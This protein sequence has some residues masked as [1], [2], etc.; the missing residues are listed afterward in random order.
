MSNHNLILVAQV[1]Q[2]LT[3][4]ASISLNADSVKAVT[5]S[6]VE[7]NLQADDAIDVK[8]LPREVINLKTFLDHLRGIK[9]TIE[10]DNLAGNSYTR[11]RQGHIEGNRPSYM[12][13]GSLKQYKLGVCCLHGIGA[14]RAANSQF[15]GSLTAHVDAVVLHA[16]SNAPT[17]LG[18]GGT[19]LWN[20][21]FSAAASRTK[22]F[23]ALILGFMVQTPD[24]D[25]NAPPPPQ[26][27]PASSATAA[28]TTTTT[29]SATV[30]TKPAQP[31]QTGKAQKKT[32]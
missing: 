19:K 12:L 31:A 21:T 25:P 30:S 10:A 15:S 23:L 11:D 6:L 20:S 3:E 1:R 22:M 5:D 17:G 32:T 29:T 28:P 7:F 9:R 13:D 18:Q 26:N 27:P 14:W 8:R 16:T 2:G 24:H 4:Q